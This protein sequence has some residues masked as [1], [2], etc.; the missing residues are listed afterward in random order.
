V[1]AVVARRGR[2]LAGPRARAAARAAVEAAAGGADSPRLQALRGALLLREDRAEAAAAALES[3]A[4][5]SSEPTPE[6]QADLAIARSRV[7]DAAGAKALVAGLE[8]S[9]S[10]G[11][12]LQPRYQRALSRVRA[13]GLR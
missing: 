4:A 7:G 10:K 3:A 12:P 11:G 8:A 5:G 1:R 6:L 13:A 9:G 2:R